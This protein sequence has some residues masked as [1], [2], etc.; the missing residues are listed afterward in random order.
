M[1]QLHELHFVAQLLWIF[2]FSSLY[3]LNGLQLDL[4][5]LTGLH[6]PMDHG[7]RAHV[8]TVEQL[9]VVDAKSHVCRCLRL[10]LYLLRQRLIVVGCMRFCGFSRWLLDWLR[11]GQVPDAHLRDVDWVFGYF[12]HCQLLLLNLRLWLQIRKG[13]TA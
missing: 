10:R 2:Y 8:Q 4:D 11:R 6:E 7:L 5:L 1:E 12:R 3:L 13:A 9:L